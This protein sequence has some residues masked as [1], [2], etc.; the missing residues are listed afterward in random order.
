[1]SLDGS[2]VLAGFW[3]GVAG[4]LA[5]YITLFL[6]SR[7]PAA[8]RLGRL[9]W[10][11][12]TVVGLRLV[13]GL[14]YPPAAPLDWALSGTVLA[15]GL[16]LRLGARVW[17]VREEA[18]TLRQQIET[19]CRGLFLGCTEAQ[20]GHLLLTAK[21]GTWPLRIVRISPRLQLV[22]V[23]HVAGPGKAALLVHWLAKQ[24]PGPVPRIR[25]VLKK[26]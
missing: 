7:R 26:E 25:V 5:V 22:R 10:L 3:W 15:S 18:A 1:V 8:L 6:L 13:L 12:L 24:Y 11:A 20:P 16:A 2:V 4:I 23:P 17:L 9:G 21:A 14:V 19:A